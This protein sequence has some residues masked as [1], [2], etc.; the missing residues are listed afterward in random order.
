[1]LGADQRNRRADASQCALRELIRAA[2]AVPS[3]RE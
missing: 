3:P 1:M 2:R